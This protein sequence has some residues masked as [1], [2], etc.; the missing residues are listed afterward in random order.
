MRLR[1]G[2]VDV[3]N[4]KTWHPAK[5]ANNQYFSIAPPSNW[6]RGVC[7]LLFAVL[8]SSSSFAAVA[9]L[10]ADGPG[11]LPG[12][13]ESL[14][15][16]I[17]V[18]VKAAGIEA[19]PQERTARF[20]KDAVDAGLDCNLA[21]D[22]CALRAGV[23]AGADG[24][25]VPQVSR[26]GERTVMVL[27]WLSLTGE[28]PR[29]AAAVLDDTDTAGSLTALA[30]RLRDPQSA[31]S[32]P[33]PLKLE[34]DPATAVVT[35]DDGAGPVAFVEGH[36]WLPPG[37]HV[38]HVSADGY[39]GTEVAVEVPTDA[40]LADRRVVLVKS[41]PVVAGVGLGLVGVGGILLVG[42]GIGAGLAEIVLQSALEPP[43]RDT[44]TTA[45]RV[46]FGVAVVGVIVA[47]VGGTLAIVGLSE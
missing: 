8:T 34:L 4:S 6:R 24:V 27:R 2:R 21:D 1:P 43:A 12:A 17:N 35:V 47:A 7:A 22:E 39:E 30:R 5:S 9:V 46:S 25:I 29:A 19:Q 44:V 45:G 26:I 14:D 31:P 32:T 37:A 15:A 23:A 3:A 33:L 41:F 13:K 38:I 20:I 10:P 28:A 11:L 16:G 42:G 18:A 36:V 40:L